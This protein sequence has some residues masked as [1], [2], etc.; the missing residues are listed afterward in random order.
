MC[1]AHRGVGLSG[2]YG[3]F[4][5]SLTPLCVGHRGVR[6]CSVLLPVLLST[7]SDSAVAASDSVVSC[8]PASLTPRCPS[9]C[10]VGLCGVLPT[11]KSDSAV[12]GIRQCQ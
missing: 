4:F 8:S 10:E 3:G 11:A 1:L 5:N 2:E 6:L 9:Y 7:E 12:S